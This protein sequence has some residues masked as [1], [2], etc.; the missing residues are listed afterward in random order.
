MR[1]KS[2][3]KSLIR[4]LSVLELQE[5]SQPQATSSAQSLPKTKLSNIQLLRIE[6]RWSSDLCVVAATGPS[7]TQQVA[8]ACKG[9]KVVV[10]NDAYRLIPNAQVLY[11]CDSMWWEVH[12][13]CPDFQGEKWSSHGLTGRH[14]DKSDVAEKFGLN[15]VEG[16]EAD[17]FSLDPLIIHYGSNSGFQAINLAILFGAKRIVLVGFDMRVT[18]K[19]HFFGDHPT[20]LRNTANYSNFISA[21]DRAAKKLPKDIQILNATPDSALNCFE[22]VSLEYALSS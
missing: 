12:K 1:G 2:S 15:L 17:G 20:P 5:K 10:V 16:K 7:L 3:G 11:A 4:N 6:P 19:R 22:K 8:E 14:N 21:F 13:G 18:D 9:H